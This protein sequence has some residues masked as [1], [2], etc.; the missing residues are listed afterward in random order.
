MQNES[1]SGE[2]RIRFIPSD[3]IDTRSGVCEAEQSKNGRT[4]CTYNSD[5]YV[6]TCTVDE[7]KTPLRLRA[8]ISNRSI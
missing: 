6:W 4:A 3:T 7:D 8:R 5:F 1:L 2:D